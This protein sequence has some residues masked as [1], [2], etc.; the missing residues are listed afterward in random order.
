MVLNLAEIPEYRA[1]AMEK[2]ATNQRIKDYLT[3]T[4]NSTVAPADLINRHI[5]PYWRIPGSTTTAKNFVLLSIYVPRV[6]DRTF[7]EVTVKVGAFSFDSTINCIDPDSGKNR[8]RYDLLANELDEIFNGSDV[9]GMKLGLIST[10]ETLLF[11]DC[12][13]VILTYKTVD[14]NYKT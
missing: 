10:Q 12:Y 8:L 6:I 14:F 4:V 3:D 11:D 13:G 5:Y 1:K 7:K 9:F 2:I